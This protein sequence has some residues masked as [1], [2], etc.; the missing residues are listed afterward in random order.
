MKTRIIEY[1]IDNDGDMTAIDTKPNT[2]SWLIA[3]LFC[4]YDKMIKIEMLD[5]YIMRETIKHDIND[6]FLQLGAHSI[7]NRKNVNL[8]SIKKFDIKMKDITL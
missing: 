4:K 6:V 5:G 3:Y 7:A 8:D 2:P 1:F